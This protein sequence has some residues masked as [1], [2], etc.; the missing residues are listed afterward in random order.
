[1][2]NMTADGQTMASVTW[3]LIM[4]VSQ[5]QHQS[6]YMYN[7]L[8]NYFHFGRCFFSITQKWI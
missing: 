8:T 2:K 1:M 7:V 4:L 6:S 5:D 3:N